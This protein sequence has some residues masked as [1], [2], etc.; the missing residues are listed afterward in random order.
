MGPVDVAY[1]GVGVPL[2]LVIFDLW[3]IPSIPMSLVNEVE[4]SGAI[5]S[6]LRQGFRWSVKFSFEDGT[7]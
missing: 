6:N 5:A 7:P 3:H 4:D 1:V 2:L